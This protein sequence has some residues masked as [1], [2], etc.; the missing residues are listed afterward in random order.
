MGKRPAKHPLE[1]N[2]FVDGLLDY[3]ESSEG[4]LSI[5]ARDLAFSALEDAGVDAKGR[6]IVWSDGARLS[7]EESA[8][9]IHA[10]NPDVPRDQIEERVVGWLENCA[11]E[12]YSESQLEELDRLTEQWLG[13]YARAS[14]GAGK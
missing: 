10:A 9:R 12:G 2:P 6:K 1:D 13:D 4:Q 5:E 3:M 8:E 11:P 14:R 7:I